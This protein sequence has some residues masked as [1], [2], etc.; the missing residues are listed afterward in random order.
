MHN[1]GV[2]AAEGGG[3]KPDYSTAVEW[4]RRA[5][6]FGVRD[7]QFNLAVLLARGLGTQQDLAGSYLWFSIV[8]GQ[9]DDDAGKKRDEISAR[10]SPSELA[11]ARAAAERWRPDTPD[12]AANEIVAPANGWAEPPA[13]RA[14][15]TRA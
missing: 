1:L 15:A 10:L 2:M 6:Q 3:G 14:G 12:K 8:A 7:S 9:G 13:K 5:A 11:S 4:F